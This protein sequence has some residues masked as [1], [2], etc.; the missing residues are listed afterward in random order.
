MSFSFSCIGFSLREMKRQTN[1]VHLIPLT[2]AFK[3]CLLLEMSVPTT[4]EGWGAPC[5]HGRVG[6][7]AQHPSDALPP[8]PN[9]RCPGGCGNNTI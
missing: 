1:L 3:S 6:A 4:K 8:C 7:V 9:S 5:A 2:L